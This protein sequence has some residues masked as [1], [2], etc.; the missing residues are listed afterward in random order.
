MA[1]DEPDHFA[2]G[3]PPGTLP[4]EVT[5]YTDPLCPWSWALEPQWRRLRY[6]YHDRLTWRYVMGGM[7]ANWQAYHDPLNSIHNPSQ[8]ASQWYQVRQLTGMP[9]EARIWHDD[10]PESSYPACLAVKAAERQGPSVGEAFLRFV[11][12]AVMI[13]RRN[14]ARGEILVEIAEEFTD[15]SQPGVALDIDQFRDDILGPAVQDAFHEDL[16]E[17]RYRSISRFPTLC[18][19]IGSGPRIALV[20]YRPYEAFREALIR[21]C[22]DIRPLRDT[23]D[24]V[25]MLASWGKALDCEVAE[26]LHVEL[27]V[28]RR[29][30]DI[31]L[32]A[33]TLERD[34][35]MPDQYRIRRR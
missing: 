29:L 4:I 15:G 2:C 22:P 35:S 33:G 11:R 5:Y 7:I 34:A 17:V 25:T 1:L 13:G 30:L 26:A 19:S 10:P 3:E 32:K 16:R 9:L 31:G 12:E 28:A 27:H 20:G 14:V 21:L 23:P 6:E 8:M 24:V 18:L